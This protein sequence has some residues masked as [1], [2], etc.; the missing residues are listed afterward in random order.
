MTAKEY[1]SIWQRGE[2]GE[3][4][5]KEDWDLDY[6][7]DGVRELVEDYDFTWDKQVIIP[8]EDKLDRKSVV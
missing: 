5:S 1:L 6:I 8:T 4:V 2:E 7:V 3:K